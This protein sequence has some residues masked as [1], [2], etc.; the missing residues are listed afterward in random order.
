MHENETAGVVAPPPLIFGAA[1]LLG[2]L[3]QRLAPLPFLPDGLA[4]SLGVG[5][6]ALGVFLFVWAVVTMTRARTPVPTRRATK[7]IVTHGPYRFTR[8]PIYLAFSLIQIGLACAYDAVWVLITLALALVVMN[9]GVI[10]REE[11]YLTRRFGKTYTDYRARVR[12]WI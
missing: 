6:S 3:L 12:R 10:S 1:I 11:R 9:A 5:V 7:R 4:R 8:N 2:A